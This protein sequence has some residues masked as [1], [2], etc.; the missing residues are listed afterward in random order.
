MEANWIEGRRTL[1]CLRSEAGME[2][3]CGFVEDCR[4]DVFPLFILEV[5]ADTPIAQRETLNAGVLVGAGGVSFS[6][7]ETSRVRP[8]AYM[9]AC[10]VT[11][12]TV[13]LT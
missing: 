4:G 13:R 2:I 1:L 3:V 8:E 7:P 11:S 9:I 10:S 5:D 12:L 6:A